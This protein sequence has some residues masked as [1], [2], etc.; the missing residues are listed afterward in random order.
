M[1][2]FFIVVMLMLNVSAL[3]AKERIVSQSP[4]IT[5]TLQYLGVDDGIVGVSRY[6]YLDLPK[7]GG[8]I[9]PDK[10]AIAALHPDVVFTSDW[11]DPDVLRDATPLGARALILHG[12]KAM[13][14]VEENIRTISKDLK[15]SNGM[16]RSVEFASAW[17]QAAAE[18]H[19]EGKRVLVLSSCVGTPFSF[20]R[21][22]Y[23]Y[24]LFTEAGFRVVETHP[25]IRHLK[26]SEEIKTID[27]L[28]MKA[29]PDVVFVLHDTAH[30][31]VV[32][33]EG[34]KCHV[35]ELN[36]E[37]FVYPAPQILKGLKDLK[38]WKKL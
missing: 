19:G 27:E 17:R 21:N 20:G 33:L 31:C 26:K 25:T 4:Y 7:T 35:V 10:E 2:N 34:A 3:E 11:T 37:H 38:A 1:K 32:P 9:D 28:L 13:S 24:D 12:F 23:I 6:D 29:R 16:K 18:V 30:G 36:G 15:L 22:T 8:I 5:Y 14:E